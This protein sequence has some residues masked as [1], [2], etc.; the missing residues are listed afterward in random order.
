MKDSPI[1]NTNKFELY[2]ACR[3]RRWIALNSDTYILTAGNSHS[4]T[5]DNTQF[6]PNY[7]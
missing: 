1:F 4:L 6:H 5:N 7:I 2:R 3:N